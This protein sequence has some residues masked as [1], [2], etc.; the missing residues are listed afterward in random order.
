MFD[1][2]VRGFNGRA[3]PYR[4]VKIRVETDDRRRGV[5]PPLRVIAMQIERHDDRPRRSAKCGRGDEIA[6]AVVD[7]STST[8]PPQIE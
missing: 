3:R 7:A 2:Q 8:A 5:D 4:H 1:D 6:V